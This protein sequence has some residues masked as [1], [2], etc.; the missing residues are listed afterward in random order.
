MNDLWV[1]G[2]AC[3]SENPEWWDTHSSVTP[4]NE[5][6]IRICRDCPV[7]QECYDDA[8]KRGDEYVIRGA[9][10]FSGKN[11]KRAICR[12]CSAT[13]HPQWGAHYC[14]HECRDAAKRAREA[15]RMRA[16]N[17]VLREGRVLR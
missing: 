2:A 5:A 8:V 1:L 16:A 3:A 13:F 14:S 6:A 12:R 9:L 17:A 15:E 10:I 4:E 11:A 7:R